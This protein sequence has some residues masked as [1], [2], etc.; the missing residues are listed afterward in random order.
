[1]V[2]KGRGVESVSA[3]G[4]LPRDVCP[5]GGLAEGGV[6]PGMSPW[7]WVSAWGGGGGCLPPRNSQCHSRYA[8]YLVCI[9]HA[10]YLLCNQSFTQNTKTF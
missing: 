4:C 7:E 9:R 5:E 2:S 1:M 6:Y 8:S 3:Q 10:I